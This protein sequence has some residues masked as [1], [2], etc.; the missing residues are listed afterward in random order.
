MKG[1]AWWFRPK[2]S[3]SIP[4]WCVSIFTTNFVQIFYRRLPCAAVW[5]LSGILLSLHKMIFSALF[6]I[7]KDKNLSPP[8]MHKGKT[9]QILSQAALWALTTPIVADMQVPF[10]NFRLSLS[11]DVWD[12]RMVTKSNQGVSSLATAFGLITCSRL[13]HYFVV[14]KSE[15]K[16]C[17]LQSIGILSWP[18]GVA[19]LGLPLGGL[20]VDLTGELLWVPISKL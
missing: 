12:F 11:C 14:L 6:G 4:R 10:E 8:F 1:L 15:T 19:L 3:R 18:R 2:G 16:I 9:S 17:T 13:I 5:L 7:F 20:A